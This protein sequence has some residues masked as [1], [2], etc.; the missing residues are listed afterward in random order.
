MAMFGTNQYTIAKALENTIDETYNRWVVN[1]VL[2]TTKQG[3]YPDFRNGFIHLYRPDLDGSGLPINTYLSD[4]FIAYL[5]KY[6]GDRKHRA[7]LVERIIQEYET[8]VQEIVDYF[9]KKKIYFEKK[10]IVHYALKYFA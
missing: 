7:V 5:K 9:L 4:A 3:S 2:P 8:D 6:S 1:E 10:E